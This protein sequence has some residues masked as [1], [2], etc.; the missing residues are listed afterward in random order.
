MSNTQ[1][2]DALNYIREN[3]LLSDEQ[4][5]KVKARTLY[6]NPSVRQAYNINIV[7]AYKS[8]RDSKKDKYFQEFLSYSNPSLQDSYLKKYSGFF[9]FINRIKENKAE[10]TSKVLKNT[11]SAFI[12]Y[13][14]YPILLTMTATPTAFLSLAIIARISAPLA[15]EY[16]NNNFRNNNSYL[17]H[18]QERLDKIEIDFKGDSQSIKNNIDRVMSLIPENKEF[19]HNQNYRNKL[20]YFKEGI[21]IYKAS[22]RYIKN[23][24]KDQPPAIIFKY[25]DEVRKDLKLKN[26]T[27]EEALKSSKFFTNKGF[28]SLQSKALL[29][30]LD[31]KEDLIL[32]LK[33]SVEDEKRI[34]DA[35]IDDI[36]GMTGKIYEANKIYK[37][38]SIISNPKDYFKDEMSERI[39]DTI[40]KN[41]IMYINDGK[42]NVE[43]LVKTFT[44]HTKQILDIN[45]KIKNSINDIPEDLL[46]KSIEKSVETVT[47]LDERFEKVKKFVNENKTSNNIDN[48]SI[49]NKKA[50][51]FIINKID[52]I[53]KK[54]ESFNQM[55]ENYL[56]GHLKTK[57]F[58]E[59]TQKIISVVW[60]LFD[61]IK[62]GFRMLVTETAGLT[63]LTRLRF[64]HNFQGHEILNHKDK[65]S[66]NIRSQLNHIKKSA[67]RFNHNNNDIQRSI[68]GLN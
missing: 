63:T 15:V 14:L 50:P 27:V 60:N 6:G 20:K 8:F 55:K 33:K 32:I 35:Y 23:L 57:T 22:D 58:V 13:K 28:A 53:C 3:K 29:K 59:A 56:N 16:F 40:I 37:S 31:N 44:E 26:I 45:N 61:H 21:E 12:S 1:L 65:L 36:T 38:F 47:E 43:A 24:L 11:S 10:Y 46:K 39:R 66:T 42:E 4:L 51:Q 67:N 17:K 25:I 19:K 34:G 62:D 64:N 49:F 30:I 68:K 7:R 2:T 41:N 9:G 54:I 48:D 52:K 18:I 5:L